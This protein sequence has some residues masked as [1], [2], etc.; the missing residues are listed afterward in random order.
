MGLE[1]RGQ[2]RDSLDENQ[3]VTGTT[4]PLR[5]WERIHFLSFFSFWTPPAFFAFK[6]RNIEMSLFHLLPL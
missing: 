2:K 6:A 4:F 1:V 5:I 3:D